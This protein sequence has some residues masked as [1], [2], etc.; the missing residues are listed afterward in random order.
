M[1][2]YFG[3]WGSTGL[4]V[5]KE[6]YRY[7]LIEKAEQGGSVWQAHGA[8]NNS[9][10]ITQS[11]L[12]ACSGGAPDQSTVRGFEGPGSSTEIGFGVWVIDG[13]SSSQCEVRA[14]QV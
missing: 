10:R 1:A 8:P 3:S 12:L 6:R 9:V 2:R 11:P 14:R 5:R 7:S 4:P 13:C